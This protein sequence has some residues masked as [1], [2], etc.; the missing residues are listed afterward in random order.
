MNVLLVLEVAIGLVFVWVVLALAC[1]G[2]M[3]WVA[4][5]LKWR[6]KDLEKSILGLLGDEKLVEKFYAHPLVASL[7]K[8]D[9]K[10]SYIEA[11]KYAEVVFEMIM[12]AG[13]EKSTIQDGL[14]SLRKSLSGNAEAEDKLSN[15]IDEIGN[16]SI[17]K[18]EETLNNFAEENQDIKPLIDALMSSLLP[19]DKDKAFEQLRKGLGVWV[20]TNPRVSQTLNSLTT[21]IEAYVAKG[22]SVLAAA[23]N[24]V[25]DHFN[26]TMDRLRGNYRR[27]S[28]VFG[29]CLGVVI[30]VMFNVDSV[31]IT[32][33][34]W[35]DPTVRA[36]IVEKA[37][38]IEIPEEINSQQPEE[39]WNE[40]QA[41]FD[42]LDLPLGWDIEE[43]FAPADMPEKFS[44]GWGLSKF[45]GWF[46]S[47]AAAAQGA[48]FWFDILKKL[49][50][51]RAAGV[52]P[53]EKKK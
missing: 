26:Q 1:S 38:V 23:R 51:V 30:A 16:A 22:E 53:D 41:K 7:S 25:E 4:G 45:F 21:G 3:E 35:K 36:A 40:F 11:Q 8:G 5:I 28:M 2:V 12:T 9:K 6:A 19:T 29:I 15:L 47:G 24:K 37:E 48:P 18:I 10:P 52:N 42:G 46:I 20:Q 17:E 13:T 27:R 32:T 43:R 39:A 33:I 49:T 44:W 50:N 34:L 31:M 14:E